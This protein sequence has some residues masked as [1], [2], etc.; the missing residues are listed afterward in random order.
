MKK[1]LVSLFCGVII[2]AGGLVPTVS[3]ANSQSAE[4]K[5]ISEQ[6]EAFDKI[7]HE[8]KSAAIT[9]Q[10]D[11]GAKSGDVTVMGGTYPTRKGVILVTKDGKY[12]SLVGHA[13]IIYS[14]TSTVESFPS[15]GVGTYSNNW[16]K[17][18][19]V[20]GIT[21]RGTTTTQDAS[22]ANRAY[23][24]K[25]KDYNWDFT[26]INTTSKFYCSQLVYEGY[27]YITGLNLNQGGGI[28]FPI[29]LVQS[30]HTYT[31]YSK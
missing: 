10:A 7:D 8:I 28:V 25:G 5:I 9:I 22:V 30:S 16:T 18:S 19:T 14:S 21:T 29:D 1:M 31:I 17:Y 2:L 24:H 27:K 13:G 12:G 11:K 4:E 15:G 20:Y 6:L 23:S 3:H 26:N